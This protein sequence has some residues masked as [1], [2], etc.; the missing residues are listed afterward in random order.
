MFFFKKLSSLVGAVFHS[1]FHVNR[2][3]QKASK[4]VPTPTAP[5][6]SQDLPLETG[7]GRHSKLLQSGGARLRELQPIPRFLLF[8]GRF[9][10]VF[11]FILLLDSDV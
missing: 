8:Y 4:R 3:N 1:I 2:T 10:L 7:T 9:G 5:L 11:S 6:L